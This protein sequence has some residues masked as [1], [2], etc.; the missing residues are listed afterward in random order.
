MILT[1][2]ILRHRRRKNFDKKYKA[3]RGVVYLSHVPHGFYEKEMTEFFS[4]FGTVTNVNIPRS[5]VSKLF[6]VRIP[7]VSSSNLM[8]TIS[9]NW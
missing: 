1:K 9:A 6:Q 2:R 3:T 8:I 4:Q 5:N 7:L